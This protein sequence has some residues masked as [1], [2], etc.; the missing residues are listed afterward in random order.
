MTWRK[1]LALLVV[2]VVAGSGA[3]VGAQAMKKPAAKPKKA[4]VFFIEP[5]NGA[6]VTSPVHLK[7]GVQN[8]EI[9][10]VPPGDVKTAA[11]ANPAPTI[12]PARTTSPHAR[13]PASSPVAERPTVSR[14]AAADFA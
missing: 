6:T 12:S 11:A 5:K 4:R 2:A 8:F 1:Q 13:R 14:C 9:A 7:F 10:A 3:V